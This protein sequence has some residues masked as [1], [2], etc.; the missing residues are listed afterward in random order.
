MLQL[1][2]DPDR[3]ATAQRETRPDRLPG[4]SHPPTPPRLSSARLPWHRGQHPLAPRTGLD[5]KRDEPDPITAKLPALHLSISSRFPHPSRR[6]V[7]SRRRPS[8]T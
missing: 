4:R 3:A 6:K 8:A 1:I 2:P 5:N 7:P